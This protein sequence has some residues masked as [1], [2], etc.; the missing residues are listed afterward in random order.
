[1]RCVDS[2]PLRAE[3]AKCVNCAEFENALSIDLPAK[4]VIVGGSLI[5]IGN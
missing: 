5:L 3:K 2:I 1:M 4:I